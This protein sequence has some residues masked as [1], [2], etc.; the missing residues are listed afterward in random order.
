M[1]SRRPPRRQ[2]RPLRLIHRRRALSVLQ[3]GLGPWHPDVAQGNIRLARL[4]LD[5]CRQ[6]EAEPLLQQAV[7]ILGRAFGATSPA[8]ADA[9][10]HLAS[11]Y[12]I[13]NDDARAES[14]LQKEIELLSPHE[15]DRASAL[16]H[17]LTRLARMYGDR[18]MSAEALAA[19]SRAVDVGSRAPGISDADR[20]GTAASLWELYRASGGPEGKDKLL[21]RLAVVRVERARP[22]F[23]LPA[24]APRAS[25]RCAPPASTAA[26]AGH[27]SIP[28]ASAVVSGMAPGFRRCYNEGLK[29]D[30]RVAECALDTVFSSKF[31]PPEGG[32]ATVVIPVTF[33]S[34]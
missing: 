10:E 21:A 29:A 33:V 22:G 27:G 8:L 26:T 30:P 32:G 11:A 31:S 28:A 19:G 7:E 20:V 2:R 3:S 12:W 25:A 15:K 17:A 24:P 6:G 9:W 1:P 23:G 5:L 34:R 14:S 4:L 13:G 16:V 18:Q